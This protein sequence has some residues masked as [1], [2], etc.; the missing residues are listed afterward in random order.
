MGAFQAGSGW[1][2]TLVI[3]A[4][5]TA[6]VAAC[7]A[8]V[9]CAPAAAKEET[10]PEGTVMV[11]LGDGSSFPLRACS[12]AYEYA[13]WKP[14]TPPHRAPPTRKPTTE[15]LVAKKAYPVR[16]RTLEV[17]FTTSQREVEQEGERRLVS[18]R[19]PGGLAL[20]GSDGKRE[21]FR[22]EPPHRD[23]LIPGADKSTQLS[24]RALELVGETLTGTRR[25][26][27]LVSFSSLVE[28]P[29]DPAQQVVKA[30]F[31]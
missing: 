19:V 4:L 10:V 31:R 2:N 7:L 24:V 26:F 20:V 29:S 5:R 22:L 27:C 25:E 14:P 28:C 12:L 9:L 3:V 30:E 1:H 6:P 13:A 8:L 11:S 21:T 15:L 16:G 23:L 17:T 18:V